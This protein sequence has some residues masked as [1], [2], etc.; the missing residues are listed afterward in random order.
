MDAVL[1]LVTVGAFTL[2]IGLGFIGWKLL[3]GTRQD[4]VTRAEALRALAAM[5]DLEAPAVEDD[6]LGR[7]AQTP[8]AESTGEVE[9]ARVP[10]VRDP[11]TDW[12]ATLGRAFQVPPDSDGDGFLGTM[13]PQASAWRG[14][15]VAL[16]GLVMIAGAG[17]VY[18]LHHE[19]SVET[20]HDASE[21]VVPA[22]TVPL[23]LLSLSESID[24]NGTFTVTGLVGNPVSGQL[25][26]GVV[27]VV[28]LFDREGHYFAMGRTAIDSASFAPGDESPFVVRVPHG[29]DAVRYRVG[30]R[31]P[32]GGVVPHVDK[33]GQAIVGTTE[34]E[35]GA[36]GAGH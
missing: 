9:A 1:G 21:A 5:P 36:R 19:E 2:A 25:V 26:R 3:R 27:A 31:N 34:G 29:G 23:D 35:A 16:I 6:R 32:D 18:A 13:R 12:D 28:Y 33:R 8:S 20:R 15:L 7:L 22:T 11:L 14:R 10:P 4:V 24:A 17:T 30:F